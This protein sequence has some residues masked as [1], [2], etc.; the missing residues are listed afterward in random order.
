[1]PVDQVCI[2]PPV[3]ELTYRNAL[4]KTSIDALSAIAKRHPRTKKNVV[5]ALAGAF[6]EPTDDE[7]MQRMCVALARRIHASLERLTKKRVKFPKDYDVKGR[8]RLMK[9]W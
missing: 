6:P 9:A 1:M 3:F 5:A 2:M 4:T 7:R 8:Q